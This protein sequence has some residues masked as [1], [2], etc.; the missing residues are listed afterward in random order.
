MIAYKN[1][2]LLSSLLLA[3]SSSAMAQNVAPL[4][5]GGRTGGMGGVGVANGNDAAMG[6]VNPAGL[7]LIHRDTLS[8]SL[9]AYSLRAVRVDN[10]YADPAVFSG[11]GNTVGRNRVQQSLVSTIPT[12]LVY[13]VH[14]GTQRHQVLSLSILSPDAQ[15]SEY[16]GNAQIDSFGTTTNVRTTFVS[17]FDSYYF[18]PSYAIET[19]VGKG[20]QLRLGLGGYLVYASYNNSFSDQ[21]LYGTTPTTDFAEQG[22]NRYVSATSYDLVGVAGF[23][24]E[25]DSWSLGASVHSESTH[26]GGT[27]EA[28]SRYTRIANGVFDPMDNPQ[29]DTILQSKRSGS[30]EERRPLRFSAGLAFRLSEKL[31]VGADVY[32]VAG[33]SEFPI[34]ETEFQ[35]TILVEGQ[36]PQ[37][38]SMSL[39][40]NF[41]QRE[42]INGAFGFEYLLSDT[43]TLRGGGFS[44]FSATELPEDYDFGYLFMKKVDRFGGTLGLAFA[45]GSG[46]TSFA[47]SY[48]GGL[49]TIVG[50]DL[51]NEDN[52]VLA[53]R[54]AE[55][56]TS[57]LMF[58]IS[59]SVDIESLG[60]SAVP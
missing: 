12:S 47:V 15:R 27:M 52:A 37:N 1:S 44:D 13:L 51:G 20:G 34:Y 57:T 28:S 33:L 38:E 6:Y 17:R 29:P 18:G 19:R 24:L 16:A 26:L 22:N 11:S 14:F 2:V 48:V 59:G 46:E 50:F 4:P 30:Y 43:W 9:S 36:Q 58:L 3:M 41:S 7:A 35:R 10:F 45:G 60:K 21:T 40:Q 25:F 55:A 56:L 53:P 42:V 8:T 49:G 31:N 32:Y 39:T 5:M 54:E 23:Q